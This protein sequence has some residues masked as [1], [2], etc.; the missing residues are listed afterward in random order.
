MSS[1]FRLGALILLCALG[2]HAHE[3]APQE[4]GRAGESITHFSAHTE[5]FVEFP[6]L[7]VGSESPFAAHVTRLDSFKPLS[8]GDV[9]VVLSGGDAPEERFAATGA[10]SPG[11]FRAVVVPQTPG[12]RELS[13]HISG[14][15]IDDRHD[16]GPVT[17]FS[18]I[19][20]AKAAQPEE[21]APPAIPFLKEQQWRVPFATAPVEEHR[22]RESLRA[23]GVLRPRSDGEAS[24]GAPATGRIIAA[25]G[26]AAT[27]GTVVTPETVLALLAPRLSA[28]TDPAELERAVARAHRDLEQARRER[29][30]LED[31]FRTEAVPERRVLSARHDEKDAESDLE[32]AVYRLKQY[33]GIHRTTDGEPAGGIAIRSP[34]AGT[35]VQIHV[36][37]GEFV[38]E[39]RE[40]FDVIDLASLWLEVHIPE[41]EVARVQKATGAWFEVSGFSR[42][43]EVTPQSGGRLITLGGMVDPESRTSPLVLEVDNS[44]AGL[45]AG[46]FADVHV[47]IGEPSRAVAVPV[48]AIVDEAGQSVAY[49]E[50]GGESFER[51]ALT[52]G[53]RDGELV[54]VLEGLR[55]GE[56]VVTKGAYYLRLASTSGSVPAH[57]H[58]H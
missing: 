16:L 31:L 53:R 42:P 57:G 47:L 1:A 7:V 35:L 50:Q 8:A 15:G 49:V 11:I 34:I 58:A 5:L 13:I 45:R 38:E 18:D 54:E 51:R 52:L 22:I 28:D 20:Q 25:P 30:R 44:A 41:A 48:S 43:F 46:M 39:G 10:P 4:E 27:L 33:Q 19:T 26:Q 17:V 55:P 29:K 37:P 32:A 24:I 36:A 40:L 2:C 9:T 12:S 23:H 6:A 3:D 21:E 56:R 14:E